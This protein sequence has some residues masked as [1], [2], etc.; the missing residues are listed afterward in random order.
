MP[1]VSV[2]MPC[3][4]H[5]NYVGNSIESILN[6]TYPNIELIVADNGCTDNSFEV[7]NRY[8]DRIKILRLEKN[9]RKL[10]GEMLRE[11]VTGDFIAYA[12]AD[13]EWASEKIERQ[14]EAFFSITNLQ[15]C[16]T[17]GVYADENLQVYA[18]QSNNIFIQPNRSR[19]NWLKSLLYGGNCLCFPSALLRVETYKYLGEIN[20]GY[21]QLSDYYRWLIAIQMGEIHVIEKPM[22][23]FRWHIEG[24]NANDSAPS[25]EN[26]IRTNQEHMDIV[27]QIVETI[28]DELFTDAFGDE[29]VNR[30]A[31]LHEELLCEKFFLLKR[32][33]ENVPLFSE[34]V[35][36]FYY[37]HFLEMTEIL[38]NEYSF[39]FDDFREYGGH[40]GIAYAVMLLRQE[41]E[42]SQTRSIYLSSYRN[43]A[44]KLA[45]QF[46]A[47]R[48]EPKTA[49][50]VFH[51][52][53]EGDQENVRQVYGVCMALLKA[54]EK[55]ISVLDNM[56]FELM[57]LVRKAYQCMESVRE[58]A[59]L[60][61]V[62]G[63]DEEFG[64]FGQ[65]V[66]LAG[67]NKIDLLEAVVP[68]IQLT[69]E[70]LGEVMSEH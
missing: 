66:Q 34:I 46:Y 64:L 56:Y 43:V 9:N 33:A 63:N 40:S 59:K 2:A 47:G 53:S 11:A 25:M 27:L 18:D 35:L 44:Q 57:K 8:R 28:G 31:R 49:R 61:G 30:K 58:Q 37:N 42:L 19:G 26:M 55:N 45:E 51:M 21:V 22:V 29:F 14:M 1:L 32:M 10:C 17:W 13:D 54:I 69:V 41:K 65:L 6:Q 20:R 70:Q 3:Y 16:F 38:R 62:M 24:T 48:F 68:Y 36:T 39:T 67:E 50:T 23:K 15:V 7:I 4:N 52:L 60:V 12:T 5:G